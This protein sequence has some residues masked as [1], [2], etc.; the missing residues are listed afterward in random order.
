MIQVLRTIFSGNLQVLTSLVRF[1][2]VDLRDE[3]MSPSGA[4]R[5]VVWRNVC[6]HLEKR[7]NQNKGY[8]CPVTAMSWYFACKLW[9]VAHIW[10]LIDWWTSVFFAPLSSHHGLWWGTPSCPQW[11]HIHS[12]QSRQT[13]WRWWTARRCLLVDRQPIGPEDPLT[14]PWLS[15]LARWKIAAAGGWFLHQ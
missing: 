7:K 8:S 6:H 5:N 15:G 10:L 9:T 1:T 14:Q 4:D 12:W 11:P 3:A 13:F 2:Y